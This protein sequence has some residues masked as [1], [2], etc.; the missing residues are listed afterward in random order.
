MNDALNDTYTASLAYCLH[1]L[2]QVPQHPDVLLLEQG[3]KKMT[4][5][6]VNHAFDLPSAKIARIRSMFA[7]T[8]HSRVGQLSRAI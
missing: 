5:H 1:G 2:K 3:R 8:L 7:S 4:S 6:L